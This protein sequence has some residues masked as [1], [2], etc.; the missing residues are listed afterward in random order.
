MD[1]GLT[2]LLEDAQGRLQLS[3]LQPPKITIVVARV[4]VPTA[5]QRT[6]FAPPP[7]QISHLRQVRTDEFKR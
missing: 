7:E 6:T 2:T 1:K 3:I 4:S 5:V